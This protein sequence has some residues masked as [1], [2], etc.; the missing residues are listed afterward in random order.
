MKKSL[1]QRCSIHWHSFAYCRAPETE[2]DSTHLL[3]IPLPPCQKPTNQMQSQFWRPPP[4][5]TKNATSF[6]FLVCF[7][8]KNAR[9]FS[10]Q[11]PLPLY[12]HGRHQC[13]KTHLLIK[14]IPGCRFI[15]RN[16]KPDAEINLSS[17]GAQPTDWYQRRQSENGSNSKPLF[18]PSLSLYP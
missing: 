8:K 4:I 9:P 11:F 14:Q 10:D 15:S 3:V 16:F 6:P 13:E 18:P 12:W 17:N 7:G 5:S 1:F 2:R